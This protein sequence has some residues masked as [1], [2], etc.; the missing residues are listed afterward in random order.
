MVDT[1]FNPAAYVLTAAQTWEKRTQYLAYIEANK[2]M[3]QPFHVENL[4]DLVPPIY[5]GE[6]CVILARGHHGKSTVL[7]DVVWKA[8]KAIEGKANYAVALVSHEDVAE[9]TAGQMARRYESEFEFMD[10]QFIHIG[11][12][13]GMKSEQ[14]ADLHMTN[15]I[16]SLSYGLSRFGENMRYSV[17]A[18]DYIQIQPPD[19]FRSKMVSQEQRRLQ[20][21][22]DVKRWS[23]VGVEF[24]CPV[25]LA[26]Q[27]LQKVQRSNYSEK[28]RIPGS[29]DVEEAKEIYNIP[30]A[31]YGYWQPK[32]DHPIGSWVEE[33]N[34]RFQ[35][36]PGI[37]FVRILKRRYAEELGFPDL[38]GRV[39]P[40][41]IE[42]SGN[43]IYDPKYHQ[44]IYASTQ[45][46]AKAPSFVQKGLEDG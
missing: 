22:D 29:A 11:R 2:H 43:F 25:Y 39:F 41:R 33:G 4:R 10:D 21:A 14:V 32:H 24:S 15:I 18:N 8:Q 45:G 9:R 5:P 17:I 31:V 36:E 27:A 20:I 40:L 26:S 37:A 16:A 42:E 13:F 19:P 44:R 6:T 34:W 35:V 46:E 23:N 7:K 12:S 1:A 28:I 38:V 3:A 30:D